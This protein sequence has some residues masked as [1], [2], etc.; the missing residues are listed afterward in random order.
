MVS[1]LMLLK[2]MNMDFDELVMWVV[3]Q[4]PGVSE[5]ASKLK[6]LRK[7]H[8]GSWEGWANMFMAFANAMRKSGRSKEL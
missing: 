1:I 3:T 6:E 8:E 5:I 2:K 7:R 4:K